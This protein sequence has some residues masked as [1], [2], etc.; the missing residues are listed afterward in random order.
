MVHIYLMT[1]PVQG[2][3][4]VSEESDRAVRNIS[5]QRKEDNPFLSLCINFHSE[6]DGEELSH[7]CMTMQGSHITFCSPERE[8]INL[9]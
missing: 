4:F 1:F 8:K 5:L 2:T 9:V 3:S 7:T 6:S